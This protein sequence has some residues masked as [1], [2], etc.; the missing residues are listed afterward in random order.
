MYPALQA[1]PQ[2]PAV[3]VDTAFAGGA[4]TLPQAPQ[5]CTSLAMHAPPHL[6]SPALQVKSQAPLGHV[7][8]PPAGAGQTFVQLPQCPGSLALTHW[9]LQRR[10]PALQLNPHWA[11]AQVELA[12]GGEAQAAPHWP[13]LAIS[14][15]TSRHCSSQSMLPAGQVGSVLEPPARR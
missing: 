4:Q 15:E 3:Q 9:S 13:Q 1:K 8:L 11:F 2:L 12:F 10:Y 6:R 14:L 5:F 7:A